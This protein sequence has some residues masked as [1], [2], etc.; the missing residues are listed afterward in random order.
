MTTKREK[1]SRHLEN[2]FAMFAE[3]LTLAS[4][5]IPAKAGIQWV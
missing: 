3:F 1:V 2:T 5:V 4:S